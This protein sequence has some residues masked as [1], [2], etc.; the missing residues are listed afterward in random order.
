MI[1]NSD[2][3]AAGGRPT[4]I[5]TGGEEQLCDESSVFQPLQHI[6]QPE[7]SKNDQA[8][9]SLFFLSQS[10]AS[11]DVPSSNPQPEIILC[12]AH[13][14]AL[15]CRFAFSKACMLI[16]CTSFLFALIAQCPQIMQ[17]FKCV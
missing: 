4:C 16:D 14:N 17:E 7:P 15:P 13:P 6:N 3:Q 12:C 1:A 5:A 8:K 10:K 2:D 11:S 9:P